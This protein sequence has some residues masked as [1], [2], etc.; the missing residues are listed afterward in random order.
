V[1]IAGDGLSLRPGASSCPASFQ[2]A[3]AQFERAFVRDLLIANDGNITRAAQAGHKNRRAFWE[4][5]RKHG[6][7]VPSIKAEV[8]TRA[9]GK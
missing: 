8:K 7:D 4:L 6:I 9:A 3:K 5:I 1:L 2:E